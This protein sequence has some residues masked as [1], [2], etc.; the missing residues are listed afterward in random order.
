MFLLPA[1]LRATSLHC[2]HTLTGVKTLLTNVIVGTFCVEDKWWRK[3]KEVVKFTLEQA[4]RSPKGSRCIDLLFPLTFALDGGGWST[5][6]TGRF[7]PGKDP[8]HIVR[9]ADWAAGPVWTDA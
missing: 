2:V 6:R 8:I 4:K 3:V 5:P 1:N 9:E 7:A